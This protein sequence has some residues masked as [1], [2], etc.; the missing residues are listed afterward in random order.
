M[1]LPLLLGACSSTSTTPSP[2]QGGPTHYVVKAQ[3]TAFYKFGPAQQGGPD[4]SLKKGAQVVM[5]ERSFGYSRVTDEDGDA[6]YVATEDIAPA[7]EQPPTT[8]ADLASASAK[9][10][11][12]SGRS[13]AARKGTPDFEQPNDAALPSAQPP[14]D[15]PAPSFRY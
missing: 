7:P 2:Q 13:G 5:V 1:A 3:S 9:K 15:V 14:S 12:S 4:L 10:A 6:G 11:G 8:A